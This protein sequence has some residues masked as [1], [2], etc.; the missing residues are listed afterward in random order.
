MQLSEKY[1]PQ[2]P[3]QLVGRDNEVT[4]MRIWLM[5]AEKG[6]VGVD[7]ALMIWGPPGTGKTCLVHCLAAE[8]QYTVREL[9]ASDT[10]TRKDIIRQLEP[11]FT[12]RLQKKVLVVLEEVDGMDGTH[13]NGGIGTIRELLKKSHVPVILTAN[14]L[15]KKQSLKALREDRSIPKIQVQPLPARIIASRLNQIV[16]QERYRLT[17]QDVWQLAVM[18]NGDMRSAV[19]NLEFQ[20]KGKGIMGTKEMNN[21][22]DKTRS[23]FDTGAVLFGMNNSL[24]NALN[25][26]F[27]DLATELVFSNYLKTGGSI[28]NV[29]MASEFLSIGDLMDPHAAQGGYNANLLPYYTAL[30]AVCPARIVRTSG[31]RIT[32]PSAELG[33]M[34]KNSSTHKTRQRIAVTTG[35]SGSDLRERVDFLAKNTHS[36]ITS[37]KTSE[38]ADILVSSGIIDR[39]AWDD[40]VKL[41]LK[42]PMTEATR[43]Q[44][45]AFTKAMPK[46]KATGN[47]MKRKLKHKSLPTVNIPVFPSRKRK[48]EKDIPDTVVNQ[49]I[50][51]HSASSTTA[52]Q[53]YAPTLGGTGGLP[54]WLRLNKDGVPLNTVFTSPITT[55]VI[56]RKE[57]SE[58]PQIKRTKKEPA[59]GITKKNNQFK[60][61][62]VAKKLKAKTK[63]EKMAEGIRPLSTFFGSK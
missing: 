49:P 14:E 23:V 34:S 41:Q 17:P 30:S 63:R 35:W 8:R 2:M 54:P 47:A 46:D 26:G 9:N 21:I 4:Q 33:F 58:C 56:E 45:T 42:D 27:D 20:A 7:K 31:T 52:T 19:N 32:F 24:E 25:A 39:D 40:V 15:Y 16:S 59:T 22:N 44:K 60:K 1:R 37:N 57:K 43:S 10:R 5:K 29:A 3:C 13:D 53:R 50:F 12:M 55:E 38:A 62:V 48:R 61:H 6:N 28:E 11:I 51:A 36:L 18:A